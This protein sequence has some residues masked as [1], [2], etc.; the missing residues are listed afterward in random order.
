MNKV[1]R[2]SLGGKIRA[3]LI[4]WV[5]IF[6]STVIYINYYELNDEFHVRWLESN[7]FIVKRAFTLDV[8]GDFYD[9]LAALFINSLLFVTVGIL[10]GFITYVGM[11]ANFFKD[12][13]S[14]EKRQ[15]RSEVQPQGSH[16]RYTPKLSH[17]R[18]MVIPAA[19]K[20]KAVVQDVDLINES[21]FNLKRDYS[22]TKKPKNHYEN[23]E[24]DILSILKAYP[25]IPASLQ[26]Y[27]GQTGL[28]SHSLSV[29]KSILQIAK[30]EG[31]EDPLLK[32]IGLSHDIE[33]ILAYKKKGRSWEIKCTHY[34]Q[35]GIA[36]LRSIPSYGLLKDADRLTLNR[37]LRFCHSPEKLPLGSTDRHKKLI[38]ILK[39]A[40]QAQTKIEKSKSPTNISNEA[41]QDNR[42][43]DALLEIIPDLNING[44]SRSGRADGWTMDAH[45]FVVVIEENI[46]SLLKEKGNS[47]L[48]SFLNLNIPFMRD[49][50]HPATKAIS[51]ALATEGLLIMKY[52]NIETQTGLFNIRNGTLLFTGVFLFSKAAIKAIN[53]DLIES[54]GSS[55]Y[56]LVIQSAH[57]IKSNTTTA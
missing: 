17:S 45:T 55:K 13:I 12:N 30:K 15:S 36:L 11:R 44:S 2:V 57:E 1:S 26:G 24:I 22:G 31:F 34:H 33:K 38:G 23:L 20:G 21:Y 37:V 9:F 46:R 29:T 43:R 51:E 56:R 6:A 53:P 54:W 32:I 35:A 18:L 42:L 3:I 52:E 5:F 10:I 7:F 47:E 40:D 50:S 4:L 28:L 48:L 25:E 39:K 19:K 16:Y 41:G 8:Y 49:S 14:K 27:H